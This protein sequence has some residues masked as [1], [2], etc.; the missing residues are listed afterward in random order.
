MHGHIIII[1]A[2]P[3][4][5]V[6][7]REGHSAICNYFSLTLTYYLNVSEYATPLFICNNKGFA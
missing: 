2:L 3:V 7:G 5:V 4:A 1:N 6:V